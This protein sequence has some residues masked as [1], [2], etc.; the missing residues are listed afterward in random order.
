MNPIKASYDNGE[1]PDCGETIPDDVANGQACANCGHT[2]CEPGT[3]DALYVCRVCQEEV[4]ESN[5]REHLIAHN[6][7]AKGFEWKDVMDIFR[8]T[9][10]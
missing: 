1:C 10:T 7:N 4:L 6:P 9:E 3:A 8:P 2:F 5:L